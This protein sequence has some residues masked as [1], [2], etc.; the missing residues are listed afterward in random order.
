MKIE[1]LRLE[2]LNSLR[3]EHEIR[4]DRPPLS[5]TGLFAIV[6]E[7][8]A[9]KTTL[10]DA[11]TLAL[12]G[13]I[14]R[15]KDSKG[16]GGRVMSWGTARCCAEVEFSTPKG[17]YLA[18]WERSRAYKKA[19]GKLKAPEHTL[20]RQKDGGD[21]WVFQSEKI[22]ETQRLIPE[23]TGLDYDRFTRSV[24]LPQGAFSRFLQA[25]E[26]KRA[27]L[28]EKITGTGIYTQIGMA[29]Y[30]RHKLARTD[31]ERIEEK[32]GNLNLL[33]EESRT[34]LTTQCQQLEGEAKELSARQREIKGYLDLYERQR[35][36]GANRRKL[37]QKK[38]EGEA[39]RRTQ[40]ED[41]QRLAASEALSAVA[42]SLRRYRELKRLLLT[43]AEQRKELDGQLTEDRKQ[44]AK[45]E[46]AL[47]EANKNLDEFL[48]KLP[49]HEEKIVQAVALD[50]EVKAQDQ[51]IT[52]LAKKIDEVRTRVTT[53]EKKLAASEKALTVS[54]RQWEELEK[55]LRSLFA[56]QKKESTP[57][58]W[59]RYLKAKLA[60]SLV[61]IEKTEKRLQRS[62]M[63]QRIATLREEEQQ[64][65]RVLA[66]SREQLATAQTKLARAEKMLTLREETLEQL[67]QSRRISDLRE[68]LQ[69]GEACPVCGSTEHPALDDWTPP[70]KELIDAATEERDAARTGLQKA[71]SHEKAR[72]TANAAQ[73]K[74]QSLKAERVA[75]K[76]A[77]Y[78]TTFGSDPPATSPE[79]DALT[80]LENHLK[81]ARQQ[82]TERQRL[83]EELDTWREARA[84]T[85]EQQ[86]RDNQNEQQ[87]LKAELSQLSE[88]Q[89]ARQK[90]RTAA[91]DRLKDLLRGMTL[92]AARA[93]L[94]ERE[95]Q[96]REKEQT[97][98]RVRDAAGRTLSK[99]E[100]KRKIL[101]EENKKQS[102]ER[103]TLLAQLERTLPDGTTPDDAATN[104]LEERE[105]QQL[106]TTFSAL[107]REL[108]GIDIRLKALVEE[109]EGFAP[110][111]LEETDGRERLQQRYDALVLRDRELNQQ[112]GALREQ[113]RTDE[114]NRKAAGD[115]Q[116]EHE[117]ARRELIKWE[118]L[119]E[120]I[121]SANGDRF[122]RFAQ[123]LT[124][125]RLVSAANVQLADLL[126]GRYRIDRKPT[127]FRGKNP[128]H[129]DLEII[130][131]YQADN[132]RDTRTLSG[133]ETFLVS[134][135]LA[136]GL[137]ELAGQQASIRSLFIDEGF[138][139]LDHKL[140]DTVIDSLENLQARGKTIGLISHVQELRERI[141]HKI[142]VEKR[143]DGFSAVEVI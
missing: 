40:S 30:E 90:N 89:D 67:R 43:G 39:R 64:S 60:T 92:V 93:K 108:E 109:Q 31:L 28:L 6:G 21:E 140:L 125:D 88:A 76:E 117:R 97:A 114:R 7:T 80:K 112:L 85:A 119:N 86:R 25:D 95:A 118:K 46:A 59:G 107:D 131:T 2:N 44:L 45:E 58:Q 61:E 69:P 87:R 99:T 75:E 5:D 120:L 106:R 65:A 15:E 103:L 16:N 105:A 96:C 20:S 127:V 110:I 50:A 74:A 111:L 130:D 134:L 83:A 34:D 37:T 24:M 141:H 143:G 63:A 14:D 94:K 101:D 122:R 84:E 77:E 53:L 138:G 9:G 48:A 72:A 18:R 54:R 70:T 128:R 1:V 22:S 56:E 42:G 19:D 98:R 121:G 26:N 55:Q 10:L 35:A 23:V 51:E 142:I 113:L 78:K 3:G 82:Q 81:K 91:A 12:Y 71:R 29:A 136:L 137:S 33:D 38:A 49:A 135:A 79:G 8:G 73:E 124:L 126:D 4:F 115:L 32:R 52:S 133:G 100:Q 116:K 129:L 139:S 17:R 36:I 57:E 13:R 132:R 68:E 123:S 62:R 104:L 102:E 66:T 41:R 11:I 27:E 47:G